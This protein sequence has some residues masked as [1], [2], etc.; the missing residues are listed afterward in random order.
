MGSVNASEIDASSPKASIARR[1]LASSAIRPSFEFS[2]NP[3]WFAEY[4][5]EWAEERQNEGSS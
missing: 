5:C 2:E 1:K 3:R 4:N